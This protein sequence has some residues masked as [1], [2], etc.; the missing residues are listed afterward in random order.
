LEN[1]RQAEDYFSRYLVIKVLKKAIRTC[2][3]SSLEFRIEIIAFL[4]TMSMKKPADE[5]VQEFLELL[6]EFGLFFAS[7][8]EVR[9]GTEVHSSQM[10]SRIVLK[11]ELEAKHNPD[12]IEFQILVTS[13]QENPFCGVLDCSLS[14]D[15]GQSSSL[16]S[17]SMFSNTNQILNSARSPKSSQPRP[18]IFSE[19]DVH[20]TSAIPMKLNHGIELSKPHR[21]ALPQPQIPDKMIYLT[22]LKSVESFVNDYLHE[23]LIHGQELLSRKIINYSMFMKYTV[24]AFD[25][26]LA[27]QDVIG[28]NP[29]L[30]SILLNTVLTPLLDDFASKLQSSEDS[31][32]RYTIQAV[33]KHLL[34]KFFALGRKFA[35]TKPICSLLNWLC[36]HMLAKLNKLDVITKSFCLFVFG[37]LAEEYQHIHLILGYKERDILIQNLAN[38]LVSSADRLTRLITSGFNGILQNQSSNTFE[39]FRSLPKLLLLQKTIL[40]YSHNMLTLEVGIESDI[41]KNRV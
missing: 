16:R 9:I 38:A 15:S 27:H 12:Y 39:M 32:E 4:R 7:R 25:I 19:V 22:D 5:T 14:A 24:K 8:T 37:V 34:Q 30:I 29:E 10:K 20:Q 28:T 36:D 33:M 31:T 2:L 35:Q 11:H 41:A 1:S 26:L 23:I 13:K 21:Q 6:V 18:T 17:S 40:E 3:E